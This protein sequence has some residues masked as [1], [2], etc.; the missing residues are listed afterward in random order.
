MG[1]DDR[2][3][4]MG[5]IDYLVSQNPQAQIILYGV[6]MGGATVMDVAG[7]KFNHHK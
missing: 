7:E 1:W 5:W 6:S 3:D 4:I 2:Y